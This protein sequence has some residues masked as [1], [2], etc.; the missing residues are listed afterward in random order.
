LHALFDLLVVESLAFNIL[1]VEHRHAHARFVIDHEM[2]RVAVEWCVG[3]Q[4]QHHT[5]RQLCLF[6]IV[7]GLLQQTRW[8]DRVES[9]Q[10][11]DALDVALQRVQQTLDALVVGRDLCL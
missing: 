3:L 9:R 6:G 10:Q 1:D 8:F 2:R 5:R 11:V 4:V 7:T